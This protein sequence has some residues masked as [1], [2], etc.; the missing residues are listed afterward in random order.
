VKITAETCPHYLH[1]AAEDIVEG[2]T[3]FKCCPPIR[4][5]ANREE[6]WKGIADGTID[7]VVSDHSPCPGEMKLAQSGNFLNAWGGISSLQL[8][9][10]VMWTD[11]SQRGFSI[12]DLARWLCHG[13]ASQVGFQQ[14]GSIVAGNDADLV[15]WNPEREFQVD[16]G[17]LQHRHKM[18]PYA[19]AVLRGV[20][21]KTFLRGRKIYDGSEIYDPPSGQIVL[22]KR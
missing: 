5:R 20:V 11:A 16:A 1:F 7:V 17:R 13:P 3:V 15:I 12:S 19:G 2:A 9:L 18:T 21:E 14:K 4:G 8:R 10:P 6:L 22:G